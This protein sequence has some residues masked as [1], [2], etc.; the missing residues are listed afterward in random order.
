MS[1]GYFIDFTDVIMG[2]GALEAPAAPPEPAPPEAVAVLYE[3][4]ALPQDSFQAPVI[5]LRQPAELSY[6]DLPWQATEPA[7]QAYAAPEPV[8]YAP[9]PAPQAYVPPDP[10]PPAAALPEPAAPVPAPP[11]DTGAHPDLDRIADPSLR[12][13]IA[14]ALA[15]P[16]ARTAET[17][18]TLLQQ[19]ANPDDHIDQAFNHTCVAATTQK[20]L[21]ET[22]PAGYFHLGMSLMQTGSG[23]VRSGQV[24]SVNPE[25]AAWIAANGG[26]A[27]T[28]MNMVMQA[29]LSELG[30]G[31]STFDA[32]RDASFDGEGRLTGHGL[33]YQEALD[34][35][36]AVL[37]LNTLDG[38]WFSARLADRDG[39]GADPTNPGEAGSLLADFVGQGGAGLMVPM[40]TSEGS[41][42]VMLQGVD[43]GAGTVSILDGYGKKR[44][45]SLAEFLPRFLQGRSGG[46]DMGTD[47]TAA[48]VR[49]ATRTR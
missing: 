9:E 38:S 23:A 15:S 30:N 19:L 10:A 22:N 48:T 31:G 5:D 43:L 26:D 34:L 2:M 8:T 36:S 13:E 28:R 42:M 11:I 12:G 39:P 44:E 45:M 6:G 35:N 3:P 33:H 49:Q 47:G 4:P 32:A 41:H 29:A 40:Q 17:A 16:D 21:A 14:A 37:G 7:P 25:N 27:E 24:A 20:I 18:A 46:D 1:D